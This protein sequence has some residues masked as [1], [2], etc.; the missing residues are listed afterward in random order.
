[1]SFNILLALI[2]KAIEAKGN[3]YVKQLGKNCQNAN[4]VSEEFILKLVKAV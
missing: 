1:M 4:K 2:I 3:S